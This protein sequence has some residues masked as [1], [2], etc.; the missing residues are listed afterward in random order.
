VPTTLPR[1]IRAL[2]AL[3]GLLT[4][5]TLELVRASGPLLDMAFGQGVASAAGAALATY[6]L[7]GLL[8]PVLLVAGRR[9]GPLGPVVVGT[10]ALAVARLLVQGLT[11]GARFGVG[12]ATV[13]LGVTV[14][15]L[16]V[17][18][19]AERAGGRPAVA[20]VAVGL[21]GSVGL[22]LAL[23]TW[24]AYWRH[25]PVGW[26]VTVAIVAGLV[27]SAAAAHR[28][29]PSARPGRPGRV[30]ALGLVLGLC[31]MVLANPAFAASQSG[32]PLAVA[33]PVLGVAWLLAAAGLAR[34]PR[35]PVLQAGRQRLSR[36]VN[37]VIFPVLVAGTLLT[38]DPLVL[39]ILLALPI[40]GADALARV[41]EPIRATPAAPSRTPAGPWRTGGTAALV[42]LGTILPLLVYQLDYD[43]PLGVPNWLVLVV[44]AAILSAAGARART[45]GDRMSDAGAPPLSRAE[46][47]DP[48]VEEAPVDAPIPA[49]GVATSGRRPVRWSVAAAGVLLLLGT[50][51]AGARAVSTA[52]SSELSPEMDLADQATLVSWNL[53]YGVDPAGD[54]D[55]EQI[56]RTIEAE[57]PSVVTLQEVSR[58]WVMGGGADMA[59]WLAD[60]LGMRMSFA[61]AADGQFGNVVLTDL[62]HDEVTVVDLPYGAGPQRRSALSVDMLIGG[63]PLR[64][65]SVHVQHREENTQ[66]RLDQIGTLLDAEGAARAGIV[67]GDFNAEPGW[68]EIELMTGKAGYVSAVDVSGDASALTSPSIDPQHRIDWV[69]GRGVTFLGAEVLDDALASDHLPLVVVL[70]V[71]APAE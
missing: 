15:T 17:T 36:V 67:A 22:Q 69:F 5:V 66:T 42:G 59:T 11:A 55:L 68:P 8:A 2:T 50:G 35:P 44:A 3:V 48:G 47:L 24:D 58:G 41:L 54:V 14:L 65:T 20:A 26:S 45:P 13:A 10:A 25:D 51:L 4:L 29:T 52:R 39:V 33:G 56:A 7:P 31:A 18:A 27:A 38:T 19:L 28:E 23:G 49:G 37:A 34:L 46:D 1:P 61:P 43:V 63:G 32:L 60:R 9:L 57:H 21:A 64:V 71:G 62:P 6:L 16:A 40:A 70:R 53:H 30:W 12:L